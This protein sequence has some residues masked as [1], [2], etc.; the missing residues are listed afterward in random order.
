MLAGS[1]SPHWICTSRRWTNM[2][3]H[4]ILNLNEELSAANGAPP[5]PKGEVGLQSN[6][7][8]GLRSIDELK[9]LTRI[10]RFATNPTSPRRGEVRSEFAARTNITSVPCAARH[11]AARLRH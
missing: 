8:E 10:C 2:A 4:S 6:P 3:L 1:Q 11:R 5:L 9:A 7:G